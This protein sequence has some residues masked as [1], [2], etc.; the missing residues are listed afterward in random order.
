[1]MDNRKKLIYYLVKCCVKE[2][3]RWRLSPHRSTNNYNYHPDQMME[4]GV[5]PY[6]I[7]LDIGNGMEVTIISHCLDDITSVLTYYP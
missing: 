5:Q 6:S 7:K 4:S 2:P 1:M 3:L